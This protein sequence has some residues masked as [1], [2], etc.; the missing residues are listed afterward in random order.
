[1]GTIPESSVLQRSSS[2]E[3][4]KGG[5]GQGVRGG[6]KPRRGPGKAGTTKPQGGK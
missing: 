1:M 4:V 3:A 6:N 5:G 2:A